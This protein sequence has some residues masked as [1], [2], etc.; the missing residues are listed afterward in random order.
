MEHQPQQRSALWLIGKK[1]SS[2]APFCRSDSSRSLRVVGVGT[3]S[4]PPLLLAMAKFVKKVPNRPSLS[5][6]PIN[7]PQAILATRRHIWGFFSAVELPRP[8]K[9]QLWR[10]QASRTLTTGL[11]RTGPGDVKPPAGLAT[12]TGGEPGEE[13]GEAEGKVGEQ[14]CRRKSAHWRA[15]C[16]YSTSA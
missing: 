14:T 10:L 7:V 6:I 16:R 9:K 15:L 12:G 13:P 2:F 3:M 1:S 5:V 4:K 11:G 8:K